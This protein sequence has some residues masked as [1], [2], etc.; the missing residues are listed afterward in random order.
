MIDDEKK[1]VGD[2]HSELERIT[3]EST[4]IRSQELKQSERL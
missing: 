3:R 1:K 2:L 4:H